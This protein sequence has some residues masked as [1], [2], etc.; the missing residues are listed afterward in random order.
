MNCTFRSELFEF[1]NIELFSY[2][3]LGPKFSELFYLRIVFP[4]QVS[5]GF[6]GRWDVR[7][8]LKVPKLH[9]GKLVEKRKCNFGAVLDPLPTNN[10]EIQVAEPNATWKSWLPTQTLVNGG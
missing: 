3:A 8:N 10:P 2:I 5:G 7:K 1:W 6:G 9:C 4:W